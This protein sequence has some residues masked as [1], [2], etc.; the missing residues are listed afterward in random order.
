[1]N[2]RVIVQ[3]SDVHSLQKVDLCL[4]HN[5]GDDKQ[6]ECYLGRGSFGIITLKMY[7]WIDV[8]VKQLHIR[9]ILRDVEHDSLFASSISSILFWSV[10]GLPTL[11]NSNSISLV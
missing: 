5:P 1:M 3:T 6:A 4:L 8:A 11:Q 9:S 7:R 10:H 2:R